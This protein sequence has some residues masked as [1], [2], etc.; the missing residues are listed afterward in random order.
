CN[1][2][3]EKKLIPLDYAGKI[4]PRNSSEIISSP[5]G[6]QAGTLEDSLV[7]IASEIGVKWTR[8][9]AS[10]NRIEKDSYKNAYLKMIIIKK[11]I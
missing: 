1:S 6:I 9:G 8:L 5:F 4:I 11:I 10:W 2:V 7:A 3:E